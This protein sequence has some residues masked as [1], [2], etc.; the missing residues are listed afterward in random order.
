[1]AFSN[2]AG[3]ST[4]NK[5]DI[6]FLG[7]LLLIFFR[8]MLG[9][10]MIVSGASHLLPLFG[11]PPIFPQPLGTLH[12]SNVMLVSLLEVGLFDIVKTVELVVGLCLVFNIFVPLALAVALPVSYMVFHNS[13][14]LNARY[15]RIFSTFMAVWCLYMNIILV[16]AHIR[17]YLPM[18]KMNAP[19]GKL[20]DFK[21]LPSIF[22]NSEQERSNAAD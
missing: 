4:T 3:L 16:L 9:A 12:P 15:D 8:V 19:M 21:L 5:F 7:K 22:S 1:M 2:P 14:V 20:E 17:Y 10:W 18:L 13:I 11:F 6:W